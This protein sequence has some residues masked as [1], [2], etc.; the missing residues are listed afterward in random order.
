M[1]ARSRTAK[2]FFNS[3]FELRESGHVESVLCGT[4]RRLQLSAKIFM[5][6]YNVYY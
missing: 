6:E 5:E 4:S 2:N 3:R 1:C